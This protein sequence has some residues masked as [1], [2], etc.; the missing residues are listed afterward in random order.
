MPEAYWQ[1]VWNDLHEKP[2][3]E[4]NPD[5]HRL[6][7]VSELL[8]PPLIK[9][10]WDDNFDSDDLVCDCSDFIH[11]LFGT[12]CHALLEGADSETVKYESKHSA[13]F[14]LIDGT[15]VIVCGT[16]D[17]I[18]EGISGCMSILSDNKTAVASNMGYDVRESYV[19]QLQIYSVISGAIDRPDPPKLQDRFYIKDW[20]PKKVGTQVYGKP[21]PDAPYI[22]KTVPTA[23]KTEVVKYIYARIQDYIDNPKRICTPTER[24]FGIPAKFT[25]TAMGSQGYRKVA[26]TMDYPDEASASQKMQELQV[27]NPSKQYKIRLTGDMRC[28]YY[29]TSKSVCAYALKMNYVKKGSK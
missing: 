16:I 12:A 13:E 25:I 18:E 26:G 24:N 6:F 8:N 22:V 19:R 7:R 10:L 28:E 20:S 29:C 4:L 11:M 1:N 21:Y 27:A 2:Y 5:G 15:V 3:D 14:P 9:T 17:E 23:P